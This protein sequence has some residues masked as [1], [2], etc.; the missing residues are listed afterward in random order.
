MQRTRDQ[1]IVAED[2]P[3][4]H[5]WPLTAKDYAARLRI[6]AEW[7]HRTYAAVRKRASRLELRSYPTKRLPKPWW[8]WS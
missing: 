1:G 3:R 8:W 4:R 6:F 2:T 5:A 7:H